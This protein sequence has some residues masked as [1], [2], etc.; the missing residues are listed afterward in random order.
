MANHKIKPFVQVLP[1]GVCKTCNA[2]FPKTHPG[3]EYCTVRCRK[4]QLEKF[5]DPRSPMASDKRAI[6][7][8]LSV[9]NW[10]LAQGYDVFLP[11]HHSSSIDMIAVSREGALLRVQ[12]KTAWGRRK[13][14]GLVY[15]RLTNDEWDWLIVVDYKGRVIKQ[16]FKE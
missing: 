16:D 10:L 13:D 6:Y 14:G 11:L 2:E 15:G 4:S 7:S 12:V 5:S 9:Y 3:M 8:E 1:S